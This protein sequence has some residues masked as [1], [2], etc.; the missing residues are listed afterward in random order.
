[1]TPHL[2]VD[3]TEIPVIS[4][5]PTAYAVEYDDARAADVNSTVNAST[6]VNG[7]P[8]AVNGAAI[9]AVGKTKTIAK[10][11]AAI[12]IEPARIAVRVAR[13]VVKMDGLFE[14]YLQLFEQIIRLWNVAFSIASQRC[15][16]A[17]EVEIEK[18]I[19]QS[20]RLGA[21]CARDRARCNLRRRMPFGAVWTHS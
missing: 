12:A 19:A 8:I 17:V 11:R 14:I 6:G 1:M 20:I 7:A 9:V 21:F 2:G 15:D 13:L 18:Q 4:F 10:M 16:R 3:D 5:A